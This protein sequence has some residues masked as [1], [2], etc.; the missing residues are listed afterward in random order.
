MNRRIAVTAP[1]LIFL[2]SVAIPFGNWDWIKAP[3]SIFCLL[4]LVL[5]WFPDPVRLK[6]RR[7]K[8]LRFAYPLVNKFVVALTSEEKATE[9]ISAAQ[10]LNLLVSECLWC[11]ETAEV[12]LRDRAAAGLLRSWGRRN[13][14]E[15]IPLNIPSLEEIPASVWLYAKLDL[16]SISGPFPQSRLEYLRPWEKDNGA[17][18][19]NIR[20]DADQFATF[21]RIVAK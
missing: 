9:F 13:S 14:E 17:L 15:V 5:V 8:A 3:I 2:G 1:I 20:F 11:S 10:A 18:Y 19:H 21:R 6:F 7:N 12:N 16:S 4:I